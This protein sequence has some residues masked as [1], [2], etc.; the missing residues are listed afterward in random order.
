M[1]STEIGESLVG[2]YLRYIEGCSLVLYNC[3]LGGQ[4]GEVDVVAIMPPV[5]NAPRTVFLCE[6]T[7]HIG[8]MSAPMVKKVP[9][10]LVRLHEYAQATFPGES[11]VFQWWSPYVRAG[12]A[13]EAFQ[14][15]E[16]DWA[17]LGRSLQFVINDEYTRRV[18]E[19]TKD[20][21]EHSWATSEPAYRMLQM[22]TR[23]RGPADEKPKL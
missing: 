14:Q 17:G 7:T 3:F 20:A 13:T 10:K 23:L 9:A 6:V 22:L 2:A 1:S 4:Q 16:A 12:A 15:L 19:L 5:E 8:G 18:T 11:H 21:R